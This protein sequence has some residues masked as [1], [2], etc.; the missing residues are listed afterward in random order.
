MDFSSYQLFFHRSFIAFYGYFKA[1]VLHCCLQNVSTQLPQLLPG[2]HL[3][4]LRAHHHHPL[5]QQHLRLQSYNYCSISCYYSSIMSHH[6]RMHSL[7]RPR[8]IIFNVFFQQF[9]AWSEWKA[10]TSNRSPEANSATPPPT[11]SII[12]P[13]AS[14]PRSGPAR[15]LPSFSTMLDN[16]SLIIRSTCGSGVIFLF[17]QF[18]V[19]FFVALCSG[20]SLARNC[21]A[22]QKWESTRHWEI[23]PHFLSIA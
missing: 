19:C 13:T 2:S 16:R 7:F 17:C 12:W 23:S 20:L 18:Q 14:P 11:S 21:S 15:Y 22:S 9:T 5:Q 6:R 1:P 8:Q 4:W 3:L 10:S